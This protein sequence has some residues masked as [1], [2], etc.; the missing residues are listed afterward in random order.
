MELAWKGNV[1]EVEEFERVLE[2]H[3]VLVLVR[4]DQAG[5]VALKVWDAEVGERKVGFGESID[6]KNIYPQKDHRINCRRSWRE[7]RWEG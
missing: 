1:G 3:Q 6:K 7:V 2:V 5:K 4:R